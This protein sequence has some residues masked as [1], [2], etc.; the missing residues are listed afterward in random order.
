MDQ[1]RVS[2][3]NIIQ[4]LLSII[5]AIIGFL[6]V[7]GSSGSFENLALGTQTSSYQAKNLKGEVIH[8]LHLDSIEESQFAGYSNSTKDSVFLFLGNSQTHS[9]NQ[10]KKGERNYVERI[11]DETTNPC[12]AFSFPN[13]NLQEHLLT[14]NY[15]LTK[16]KVKKLILPVFMDDLRED[17]IRESFFS[18]LFQENYQIQSKTLIALQINQLLNS[19]NSAE[20][21]PEVIP[22]TQERSEAFLNGYLDKNTSIWPKRET[23][24]GN[25]FNWL[26]MLRNTVFGIRPGTARH[27]IS[28]TYQKNFSA[29]QAILDLAG[30][31][32]ISVYLYVP[33]IRSDV[34]L[35]YD[36][37]EYVKFQEDLKR[38]VG[39]YTN[40]KL[41]NY[42]EI[43]PGKYW[44]YKDPTNFIDN[45]E[46]DY[47]H[48]QFEG[49]RIL[50]D[51]LTSFLV[52]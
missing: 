2:H 6:Y 44:G 50:A 29:L 12:L 18:E 24:R 1:D 5:V 9:I 7:N 8:F 13:A 52:K 14:L 20:K 17:G 36:K 11:Q 42:S 38:L 39:Q 10:F 3:T 32:K 43:V 16:V 31:K 49:H 41:K 28:E 40:S 27:M 48:F 21:S 37:N 26:Y 19:R 34:Q 30:A 15:V 4:L 35:P 22:T 25:L 33:P 23:M 51:S 46:I 47:M 45:R